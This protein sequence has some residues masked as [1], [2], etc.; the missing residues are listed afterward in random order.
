MTALLGAFRLDPEH[1]T[2]E[3]DPA[4]EVKVDLPVAVEVG[5][6]DVESIPTIVR[7]RT[8]RAFSKAPVPSSM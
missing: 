2:I 4:A 5:C 1:E 6:L 7:G 8:Q 3:P